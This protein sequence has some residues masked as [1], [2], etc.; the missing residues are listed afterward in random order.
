[1]ILQ[2]MSRIRVSHVSVSDISGYFTNIYQ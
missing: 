2:F 1:M